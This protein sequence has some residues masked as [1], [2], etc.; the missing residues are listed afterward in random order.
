MYAG[1]MASTTL[2]SGVTFIRHIQ[3]NPWSYSFRPVGGQ[4]WC[5]SVT[6]FAPAFRFSV[7]FARALFDK[8][9]AACRKKKNQ[10]ISFL[11]K[12]SFFFFPPPP[13]CSISPHTSRRI[14]F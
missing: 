6:F 12:T 1:V 3:A 4:A 8:T 9:H 7:L 5:G 14:F 10:E 11:L 13:T 2:G